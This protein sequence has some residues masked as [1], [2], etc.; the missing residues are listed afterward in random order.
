MSRKYIKVRFDG[1]LTVPG[2]QVLF[3]LM[4]V[5]VG[6]GL[7][8]VLRERKGLLLISTVGNCLVC[9]FFTG[10]ERKGHRSVSGEGEM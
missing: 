2:D 4:S 3:M 6:K 5:T 7:S 9:F 10:E 8:R 1:G